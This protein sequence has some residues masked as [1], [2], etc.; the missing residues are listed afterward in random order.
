[1]L[2]KYQLS[3]CERV[4]NCHLSHQYIIFRTA[5]CALWWHVQLVSNREAFAMG[6]NPAATASC[7]D[8]LIVRSRVVAEWRLSFVC[9]DWWP[10][11]ARCENWR[12]IQ[13][14]AWRAFDLR[15]VQRRTQVCRSSAHAVL[16]T[17]SL[18]SYSGH[19]NSRMK[20]L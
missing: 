19:K 14:C 20:K 12:L 11:R 3:K 7:S 4:S 16:A 18:Q 9:S 10:V 8:S 13:R 6:R 15:S 5:R 2:N 17:E 1:M